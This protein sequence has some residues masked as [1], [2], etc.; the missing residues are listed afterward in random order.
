M[1][2]LSRTGSLDRSAL[3]AALTSGT[4]L[5]SFTVEAFSVDGIVGLSGDDI[6]Q[7][8]QQLVNMV[9]Y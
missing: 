3:A 4:V 2:Q 9:R 8:R 6:A 1:G 7:R 5:A